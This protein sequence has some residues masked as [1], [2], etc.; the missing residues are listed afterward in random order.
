MVMPA[1]TDSTPAV[2]VAA[3]TKKAAAV[4]P[5]PDAADPEMGTAPQ[6]RRVFSAKEKLRILTEANQAAASG[7]PGASGAVL[8][9]EGIYSLMLTESGGASV[10]MVC[11][12]G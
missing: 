12:R 6:R 5:A 8:R 9:R 11:S 4:V 1:K 7:E 10:R 3:K 2:P